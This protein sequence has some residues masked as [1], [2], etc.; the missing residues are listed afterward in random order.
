MELLS[1]LQLKPKNEVVMNIV[2]CSKILAA[3]LHDGQRRKY[4]HD[5]YV[6][7]PHRVGDKVA[8]L[9][10]DIDDDCLKDNAIS[11][12]YL[13]DTIEDCDIEYEDLIEI[14]GK[15]VADMVLALTNKPKSWGNRK[16]RKGEM[17]DRMRTATDIVKLIKAVDRADNLKDFGIMISEESGFAEIYLEESKTLLDSLKQNASTSFE[18]LNLALKQ[19]QEEIED[20]DICINQ[21]Q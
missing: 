3:G 8:E 12:A 16:K 10:K 14:I 6:T 11:A 13:H 9:L 7:H 2:K 4:H 5:K 19:L 21:G 15:P 1:I 20:C 17:F 18:P